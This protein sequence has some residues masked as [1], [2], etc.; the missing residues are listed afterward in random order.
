MITRKLYKKYNID[1]IKERAIKLTEKN[2]YKA[3]H[4]NI[5]I[6]EMVDEYN[7][8]SALDESLYSRSEPISGQNNIS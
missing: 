6:K 4:N 2:I 8:L 7:I 3:Y 5:I 1:S